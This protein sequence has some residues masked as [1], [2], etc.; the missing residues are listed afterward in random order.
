V[1]YERF[2]VK[3]YWLIDPEVESFLFLQLQDGSYVA[4]PSENDAYHSK[5]IPRFVLDLARIK[6]AYRWE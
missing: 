5:A 2:G 3:E 1:D 4:V 6:E